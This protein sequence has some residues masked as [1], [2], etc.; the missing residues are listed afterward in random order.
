MPTKPDI[1]M[2]FR[3]FIAVGGNPYAPQGPFDST[4]TPSVVSLSIGLP[5]VLDHAL[6]FRVLSYRGTVYYVDNEGILRDGTSSRDIFVVG[7]ILRHAT[8]CRTGARYDPQAC[9]WWW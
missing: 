3:A 7:R 9:T 4:W 8:L 2:T 5:Q 6:L 1:L